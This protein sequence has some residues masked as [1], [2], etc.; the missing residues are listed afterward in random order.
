MRMSEGLPN[1]DPTF[2]RIMKAALKDQVNKNVQSCIDDIVVA[3][4]KK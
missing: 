3:R 2:Y 1:I 4:K